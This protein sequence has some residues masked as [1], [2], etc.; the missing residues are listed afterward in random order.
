MKVDSSFSLVAPRELSA[1]GGFCLKRKPFERGERTSLWVEDIGLQGRKQSLYFFTVSA[2][3]EGAV[4]SRGL[5]EVGLLSLGVL[6]LLLEPSHTQ[7][8]GRLDVR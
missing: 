1:A 7:R 3:A 5:Q 2:C 8:V 4:V 6:A